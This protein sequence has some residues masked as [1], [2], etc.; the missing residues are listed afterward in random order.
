MSKSSV[1]LQELEIT[2]FHINIIDLYINNLYTTIVT[3]AYSQKFFFFILYN[4]LT[5]YIIII[6]YIRLEQQKYNNGC[7]LRAVL[8][9]VLQPYTNTSS[10]SVHRSQHNIFLPLLLAAF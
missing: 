4:F 9:L 8:W 6:E 2:N 1:Q 7:E 10:G 5:L 3:V